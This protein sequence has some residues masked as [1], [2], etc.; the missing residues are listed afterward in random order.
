MTEAEAKA[1]MELSR[2]AVDAD[3]DTDLHIDLL[4]SEWHAVALPN[5]PTKP[6]K[7]RFT[8]LNSQLLFGAWC[9][10]ILWFNDF[11]GWP[12]NFWLLVVGA[13]CWQPFRHALH[14]EFRRHPE[15]VR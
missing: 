5:K 8:L 14:D 15:I 2:I 11:F 4:P 6:E 12:W 3:L 7:K 10:L 9:I 1:F 13:Y